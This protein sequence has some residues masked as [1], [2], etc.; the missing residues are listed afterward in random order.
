MGEEKVETGLPCGCRNQ[1][2]CYFTKDEGRNTFTI[3][4]F[5]FEASVEMTVGSITK[6]RIERWKKE[7]G[8]DSSF[9]KMKINGEFPIEEKVVMRKIHGWP[10][11]T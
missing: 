7:F 2:R 1:C 8:G 5:P 3:H 6:E 9:V 10:D 11:P 4:Y